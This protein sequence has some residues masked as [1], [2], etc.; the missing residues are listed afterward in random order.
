[1]SR[2]LFPPP[3]PSALAVEGSDDLFPVG[4]LFCVGRNYDAHARE[5]GQAEREPPFFFMKPP[6]ALVAGGGAIAYPSLTRD[7]HHEVELVV[8][9][10]PD[11][12]IF[13]Y[14]VGLDLTRRDLQAAAK[15]AGKPW[16][17]GKGFDGAAPVSRLRRADQVAGVAQGRI[18]LTV[19]GAVR[20]EGDLSEMIWS[21]P[22]II[23]E[24]ARYMPLA[25]GDLIFTG[26]PAGVG[27]LAI[28]DRLEA[29]VDGVGT[30]AVT[31]TAPV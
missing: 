18:V 28:G 20:Q 15:Q 31:I 4:R 5:M 19:N 8:A 29:G 23:S 12:G 26:T 2:Y 16:D 13:G 17:M 1:M 11:G 3:T 21:V 30:L 22:E 24:L 27:P 9:M 7:L 14:G 25:A 10:G 6:N